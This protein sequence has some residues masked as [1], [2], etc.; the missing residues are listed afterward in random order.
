MF[1]RGCTQPEVAWAVGV[2]LESVRRWRRVWEQEGTAALRRRPAG[3]RPPKQIARWVAHEWP[4]IK[5][6][7]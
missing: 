2:C 7:R 3:G 6:G 5:K 4:R 1:E